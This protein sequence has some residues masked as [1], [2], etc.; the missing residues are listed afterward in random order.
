MVENV[1]HFTIFFS[2]LILLYE[3]GFVFFKYIYNLKYSHKESLF[4]RYEVD[5][6][7]YSLLL[8]LLLHVVTCFLPLETDNL[9]DLVLLVCDVSFSLD[10][11][12]VLMNATFHILGTMVDM[13]FNVNLY[14]QHLFFSY[15]YLKWHP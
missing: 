3:F 8:Y 14:V 12:G 2:F 15:T 6:S 13:H 7:F 11:S 5:S 9:N 1:K 10:T 4:Y